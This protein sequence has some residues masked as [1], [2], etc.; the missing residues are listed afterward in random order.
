MDGSKNRANNNDNNRKWFI[1]LLLYMGIFFPVSL[2]FFFDFLCVWLILPTILLG[3]C[4]CI[5][6]VQPTRIKKHNTF[7]IYCICILLYIEL[8][9]TRFDCISGLGSQE[10]QLWWWRGWRRQRWSRR[11]WWCTMQRS[12]GW[13]HL[14]FFFLSMVTFFSFSYFCSFL[15]F[16][17]FFFLPFSF[18]F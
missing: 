11:R 10:G 2:S 14:L 18:S 17:S 16:S 4:T 12:K 5:F 7:D 13:R 1:I 3:W 8:K 9:R 15:F 6:L